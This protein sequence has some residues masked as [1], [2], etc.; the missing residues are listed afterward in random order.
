MKKWTAISKMVHNRTGIQCRER[1]INVLDPKLN[2]SSWT[3]EED[4]KLLELCEQ[5][6]GL[7]IITNIIVNSKG[8]P[9]EI[10]V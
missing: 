5:Y 10:I 9:H 6:K 4:K 8:R 1:W 7:T 3:S 2:K